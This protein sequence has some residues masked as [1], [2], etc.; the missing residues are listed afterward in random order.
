MIRIRLLLLAASV[1]LTVL[2]GRTEADEA[3]DFELSDGK[4][5]IRLT[6]LP[7][8]ATI[9]NFWRADCPPCLRELPHLARLART[10]KVRVIAVALQRPSETAAL[11]KAM[12][13]SLQP[14]VLLLHG[15]TEPRGLL[16]RFGNRIGGLPHTVWLTSDGAL[17]ARKTGEFDLEWLT[18][19]QNTC[20]R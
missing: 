14:P 15:P 4:R 9:I 3:L 6:E 10:G 7:R 20:S 19:H 17:C 16:A 1:W 5:F 13:D 18:S 2:P 11:P 8:Q 12:Q